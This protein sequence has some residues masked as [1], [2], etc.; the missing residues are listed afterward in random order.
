LRRESS[1]KQRLQE[2]AATRRVADVRTQELVQLGRVAR[3]FAHDANN[4]L[5]VILATLNILKDDMVMTAQQSESLAALECAANQIQTATA[6]LRAFDPRARRSADG[7]AELATVLK[8]VAGMLRQVFPPTIQIVLVGSGK[9][10]AALAD[11]EIQRIL[12]NLALNARDAMSGHGT[13][14]LGYGIGGAKLGPACIDVPPGNVALWVS[15]TGPGIPETVR[16]RM[17]ETFFTT[18]GE[19]G[20]GLGLASVQESLDACGGSVEVS[21]EPGEGT[22]FFIQLPVAAER[23]GPA[24]AEAVVVDPV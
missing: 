3:F 9:A 21:S 22:T 11:C 23:G 10:R 1:A 18:K 7:N 13:L 6:R 24:G 4:A 5:Q 17:F 19:L 8:A 15:D 2:E 14:T 16:T 12:T 20:Q